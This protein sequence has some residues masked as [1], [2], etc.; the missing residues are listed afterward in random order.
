[1]VGLTPYLVMN[2]QRADTGGQGGGAQPRNRSGPTRS[3]AS[4][5]ACWRN[6][7]SSGRPI[8]KSLCGSDHIRAQLLLPMR[9]LI[10]KS[11]YA[12]NLVTH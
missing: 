3:W 4:A 9:Y 11:I 8:L 7:T 10:R 12:I 2:V 1:M 5:V 6:A